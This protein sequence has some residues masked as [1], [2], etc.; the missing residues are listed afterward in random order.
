MTD[1]GLLLRATRR[2]GRWLAGSLGLITLWQVCEALVPVAIG[3]TVDRAVATGDVSELVWCAVGICV[4]FAVLS[5]SYR[6]G[7]RLGF[8]GVQE[9]T[10]ALRTEVTAAVLR[11]EGLR[12]DR[13]AGDLLT[14]TT[15]DAE[16][17]GAFIRHVTAT[18][19]ALVGLLVAGVALARID[20]VIA[21]VV[22]VGV[23]AI[24]AVSQLLAPA[25]ARRSSARQ[26]ALGR[27]AG[28]A[29]D[30]LRGLRPLK[31]LHAEDAAM[32]RFRAVSQEAG[33]T[34]VVAGRWEGVLDGVSVALSGLFLAAIALLAGWRALDGEL[35]IG[36]L[37]AVLG[38]AQFV[39]EPMALIAFMI[40]QVARSRASAARIAEVLGA[41]ALVVEPAEP[42][43]A[44]EVVF[45]RVTHDG[46]SDLSFRAGRGDL[47]A[48]AVEEPG[49]AGTVLALLRGEARPDAGTVGLGAV[50][51]PHHV[52]L[53]E[54]TLR[55]NVDPFGAL[56]EERLAAVL[57]ASA[58]DDVA[59]HLAGGLD[60]PLG[61]D[62][63]TLSG[64]QRQRLALARALAADPAALV[65]HDPTSSVDAVTE[66]H[67][68]ASLRELRRDRATVVVSSS[69]ALLARADLVVH[70][71][72]GGGVAT[73][74]HAEL[75]RDPAYAA[76]VLR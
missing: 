37:V 31:G 40:G 48:L 47:V 74:T 41:P 62:A 22:L 14:V 18:V 8:R 16:A 4:L 28:L 34:A 65:L 66:D 12:S 39:A 21:V 9:E 42:A 57:A 5:Y 56:D 1:R 71:R 69:P 60:E 24:L 30:L 44:E 52:D 45:D 70:V 43:A 51:V 32:A 64:G 15:A 58:A 59:G 49:D 20:G 7:A 54:G 72:A 17:V 26:E 35:G 55:D 73:G 53:F 38:L 63:R 6:F 27:T 2:Q 3:I 50:V 11:P 19:A 29:S 33:R 25:L 61:P 13:L 10:H 75:T 36:E 76:A 23:P 46:L 67:V 68:A